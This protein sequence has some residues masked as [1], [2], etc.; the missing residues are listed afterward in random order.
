MRPNS[1]LVAAHLQLTR[2]FAHEHASFDPWW[3][4]MNSGAVLADY[5]LDPSQHAHLAAS[6]RVGVNDERLTGCRGS[7]AAEPGCAVIVTTRPSNGRYP[8]TSGI[9]VQSVCNPRGSNPGPNIHLTDLIKFRGIGGDAA[10]D[11]GVDIAMWKASLD[12]LCAEIDALRPSLV[13]VSKGAYNAARSW[14][15][16]P[17]RASAFGRWHQQLGV[18]HRALL[19]RLA[20]SPI[21][22]SLTPRHYGGPTE[23]ERVRAPVIAEYHKHL[24]KFL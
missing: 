24:V 7:M 21:V 8:G 15:T 13:L 5:G 16:G 6:L 10:F 18:A 19:E 1:D 2:F 17:R 11:R 14:L 22:P 23:A 20:N 12:C 3:W 4:P 9:M